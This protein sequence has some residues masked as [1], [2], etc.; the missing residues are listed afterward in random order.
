MLQSSLETG[1]FSFLLYGR[2]VGAQG[3]PHLQIYLETSGKMSLSS[4]KKIPG[5][6]RCHLEK[7]NGSSA[8]NLA[9]CSKEDEN[10]FVG[11]SAM[12]QGK[13]S[14]LVEIQGLL[15]GGAT[16]D[17]IA[18]SHF[19]KWVV[20]RK[21][22]T[23]YATRLIP[24]RDW[25]THVTVLWGTTG[26]GKTRFVHD[27]IHDS[28]FWTPGD[29]QWFDGYKGQDIVLFDDFRGEYPLAL[30]L[31]LLDRY[32]MSIPIKGGFTKWAPRKIYITSNEPP[33][34]WYPTAQFRSM[35]ALLRRI[36]VTHEVAENIY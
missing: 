26:T 21:S 30:L 25:K 24:D 34:N 33:R 31:R 28:T 16:V 13:R 7:A 11:G 32:P 35:G 1:S 3:T 15:D 17:D 8:Q 4:M 20:Y 23:A 36:E 9:Y 27:Q 10:P 12:K 2:E 18:D 14:D 6:S 22:F 19:S 5:L 29:Y